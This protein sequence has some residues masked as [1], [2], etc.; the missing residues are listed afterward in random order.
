MLQ[1][2]VSQDYHM[3]TVNP[4]DRSADAQ[5]HTE[6]STLY[7]AMRRR[8]NRHLILGSRITCVEALGQVGMAQ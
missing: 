6:G 5:V 4:M 8:P 2:L 3:H 7:T 1:P